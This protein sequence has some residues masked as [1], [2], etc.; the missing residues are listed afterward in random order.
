MYAAIRRWRIDP[1]SVNEVVR[2]VT[3]GF[4]P[5]LSSAPGFVSYHLVDAGDGVIISFST[6]E[7]RGGAEASNATAR[8]WVRQNLG[9]FVRDMADVTAGEVVAHRT[10]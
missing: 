8:E 2:R 6:F 7:E 3:E 4:V 9:T 10:R 5:E 1:D